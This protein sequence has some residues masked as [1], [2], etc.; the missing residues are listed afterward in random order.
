MAIKTVT[1][2]ALVATLAMASTVLAQ[3]GGGGQR[4]P[5]GQRGGMQFG[6][7]MNSE[8]A[9]LGRADVQKDI[10]LTDEQK[11]GLEVI[12]TEMS[13]KMRSQF[14]SARGGGDAGAGGNGQ[15]G[16]RGGFDLTAMQKQMEAMQKESNEKVKAVLTADQWNRLGQ[17][18]V[19]LGGPRMF[20]E[21]EM[22]K[23]LSLK[24]MQKL[25]I[26][27]L[28]DKQ[29]AAN[30]QIMMKFREDGADREAL[31]GELRKNDVI[32]RTAI[33]GVLT[34][35]QKATL[36]TL[37]GPKFE[38]D[39]NIQNNQFGGRGGGGFGGRG[40]GGTGGGGGGARGGGTGGG[41]GGGF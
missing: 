23:K 12:R 29:Q 5:G 9:L 7:M 8:S 34:D 15:A 39:P 33:E 26:T 19:Q 22:V 24:A 17:I 16:A 40:G 38:A 41:T 37:E 21:D 30:Q 2:F 4:G 13:A 11:K 32:L 35:E 27:E 14:E 20:L 31:S 25:S 3:G 36:K 6:N 18:K 10:K 1:F 28:I